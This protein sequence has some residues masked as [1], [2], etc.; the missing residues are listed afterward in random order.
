MRMSGGKEDGCLCLLI[1][2]SVQYSPSTVEP[3]SASTC[4][5]TCDGCPASAALAASP[6]LARLS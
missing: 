3:H 6:W 4:C 2:L 5:L 1:S